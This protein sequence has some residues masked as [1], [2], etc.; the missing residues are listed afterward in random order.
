MHFPIYSSRY[1]KNL[2]PYNIPQYFYVKN[3]W[4]FFSGNDNYDYGDNDNVTCSDGSIGVRCDSVE[5]C[6][7]GSDEADCDSGM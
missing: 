4:L 3:K 2:A 6:A 7:D 5:Q 1:N